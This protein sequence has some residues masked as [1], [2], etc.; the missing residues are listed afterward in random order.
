MYEMYSCVCLVYVRVH[1]YICTYVFAGFVWLCVQVL[2]GGVWIAIFLLRCSGQMVKVDSCIHRALSR[3]RHTKYPILT[4]PFGFCV[5]NTLKETGLTGWETQ[6]IAETLLWPGTCR[7]LILPSLHLSLHGVDTT[8]CLSP[9][10]LRSLGGVTSSL[11]DVI[12]GRERGTA[13]LAQSPSVFLSTDFT[14]IKGGGSCLT[15][16]ATCVCMLNGLDRW[17]KAISGWRLR[18]LVPCCTVGVI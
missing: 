10:E 6:T 7:N 3:S 13:S 4:W 12:Y 1:M 14:A 18:R 15:A 16:S 11:W 5:W 2:G 8:G 17:Q 9:R